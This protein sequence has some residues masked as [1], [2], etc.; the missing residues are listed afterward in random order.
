L[1][2]SRV[3]AHVALA[4]WTV[5]ETLYPDFSVVPDVV[6]EGFAPSVVD[7]GPVVESGR[8]VAVGGSVLV[9]VGDVHG[10]SPKLNG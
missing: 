4:Q 10:I 7:A 1:V 9:V 8:V 5:V 3:P 6:T 2:N